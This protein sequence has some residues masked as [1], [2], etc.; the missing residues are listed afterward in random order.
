MVLV[1]RSCDDAVGR[2]SDGDTSDNGTR[3]GGP[4]RAPNG[5]GV[6]AT[7]AMGADGSGGGV[8]GTKGGGVTT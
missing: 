6:G 2:S 5:V 1:V 7:T 8:G 4:S 3:P